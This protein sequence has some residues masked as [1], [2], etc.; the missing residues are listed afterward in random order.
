MSYP[1]GTLDLDKIKDAIYDWVKEATQ[2][3]LEEDNQIIWRNQ[4]EP[5]PARPCVTLKFISGPSPTD[6][7]PSLFIGAV[8]QPIVA[9]MQQEAVLSV[10]VFGNPQMPRPSA[11]QLAIDL[12]SSLMLPAVRLALKAGG[13]SI[14]GLG[15][16]QNLTALEET[17]YEERAG[18][19]VEMGM[20][21]NISDKVTTT[22]G[23]VNLDKTVDDVETDQTVI[24]P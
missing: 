13:V 16:P 1:A 12:N 14:Q 23:T 22:I 19:E 17:K 10:Q 5:L 21:Q 24:L 8:G 2:G 15:K 20:V 4:S 9:G 7:D 11:Y 6:R 18:F 3:V